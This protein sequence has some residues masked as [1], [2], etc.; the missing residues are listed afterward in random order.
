MALFMQ[1]WHIIGAC[2]VSVEQIYAS[3]S[4]KSW[5]SGKESPPLGDLLQFNGKDSQENKS[6]YRVLSTPVGTEEEYLED[7]EA[8]GK[9]FLEVSWSVEE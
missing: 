3:I 9:N 4:V 1:N 7:S 5:E 2:L 8:I 6:H